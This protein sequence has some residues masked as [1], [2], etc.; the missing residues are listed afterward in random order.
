MKATGYLFDTHAL[1]FWSTKRAVSEQFVQFFDEQ[2]Q[3]GMLYLS[4]ISFWEIALLVQKG[5]LLLPNVQTW[6]DELLGRTNLSLLD[7]SASEMIQSTQLPPHHK[8]PFDRLLIAQ[9]RQHGLTFVTQ[10]QAIQSY[11]VP[12]FWL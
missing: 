4:S 11:D 7:P 10:D 2:N 5:R 6:K 8:D 12:Q 1:L 3:L 9:A